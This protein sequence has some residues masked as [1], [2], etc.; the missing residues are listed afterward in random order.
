MIYRITSRV[1][2]G[3]DKTLTS[4]SFNIESETALTVAELKNKCFEK[5]K[6]DGDKY[7]KVKEEIWQRGSRLK[8]PNA[9][10]ELLDKNY[11][12]NPDYILALSEK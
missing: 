7:S 1:K 10:S 3:E 6:I 5:L 11:Q 2:V 8:E 9:D 12:F 4:K